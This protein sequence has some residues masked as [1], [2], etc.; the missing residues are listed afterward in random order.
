MGVSFWNRVEITLNLT[1]DE[2]KR[3][4]FQTILDML[5]AHLLDAWDSIS[6]FNGIYHFACSDM[7]HFVVIV[8]QNVVFY[9]PQYH[10]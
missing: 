9:Q 8:Q 10:E 1:G 5:L 7:V 6:A 2:E 4:T 3:D